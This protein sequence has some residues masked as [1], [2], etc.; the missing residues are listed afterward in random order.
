MT[1]ENKLPIPV[2][3]PWQLAS[4]TRI[5]VA[6]SPLPADTTAISLF[7]YLPDLPNLNTDYPDERLIYLKFTV[8]VSPFASAQGEGI[9]PESL[10]GTTFP[11]WGLLFDVKI[12]ATPSSVE[13][14]T[15]RPRPTD[16]IRP[17]FLAAAPLRRTMIESGVIGDQLFEGAADQLAVGKSGSQLHESFNSTTKTGSSSIS[18]TT[19]KIPFVG[20][21]TAGRGT[22]STS[23]SGG[24]DVAESLDTTTRQASEERRELLS[25]LT[26]VNNVLS[27]LNTSL[28]GSPHLR[29]LLWPLPLR[30]L[31]IDSADPNWWHSEFMKRRSSGLEGMQDFYAIAVLPRATG[32]CVQADLK[33]VF[34]I[35]PPLPL[36]PEQQF[37]S[38]DVFERIHR[39]KAVDYMNR[40][41]RP[42]TPVDDLD[43]DIMEA[44][45]I[46]LLPAGIDIVALR[47]WHNEV[48][49]LLAPGNPFPPPP[50]GSPS[51]RQIA[52]WLKIVG[53][54]IA[55][56][57]VERLP[58]VNGLNILDNNV[59]D[60][61]IGK[62]KKVLAQA[63][64]TPKI[65]VLPRAVVSEWLL[66]RDD[67]PLAI[68]T[69][70]VLSQPPT[71]QPLRYKWA[72]DV[73][74]E[75]KRAE[76]EDEITR[77]PL[78]RGQP[79]IAPL[80]LRT[81]FAPNDTGGL[82]AI[83]P[84]PLTPGSFPD[85]R[86][87]TGSVNPAMRVNTPPFLDAGREAAFAWNALD[88]QLVG[89][90]SSFKEEA[91]REFRFDDDSILNLFLHRAE[92]L[93]ADE[94]ENQP[95]DDVLQWVSLPA[96]RI[97]TLKAMN[98]TDLRGLAT[99]VNIAPAIERRNRTVK[100]QPAQAARQQTRSARKKSGPAGTPVPK[101]MPEQIPFG[102]SA[103]DA[104]EIRGAI[105]QGLQARQEK[106]SPPPT[107]ATSGARQKRSSKS[108]S[109]KIE[110]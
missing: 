16:A 50:A 78:V 79:A 3:I 107:T 35:E 13:P 19:P 11:I 26:N 38:F 109:T 65:Q 47:N 56:G 100:Q 5:L 53:D 9:T 74:L 41:Y 81:C 30:Q 92:M 69:L 33:R 48:N 85:I 105:G 88:H 102:L 60:E 82:T 37:E 101:A 97:K 10:L 23:I 63:Q 62:L 24:R 2:E 96:A 31:S 58:D 54:I 91:T 29:F 7:T 36:P 22:S 4:T 93:G 64:R 75:M 17:Y 89:E 39:E 94:P 42:G 14:A 66:D 1:P 71:E 15:D 59:I 103:R 110:S 55:P 40:R 90:L 95:L 61:W 12:N 27:L 73:W 77:S 72:T 6:A 83:P 25:H 87:I 51:R 67:S 32:F 80:S 49:D 28:V 106:N 44:S 18:L 52:G 45:R 104:A 98:I 21:L 8:S 108:S 43:V 20:S 99:A 70:H 46:P 57:L 84:R 76:Y 86:L 68:M 34:I